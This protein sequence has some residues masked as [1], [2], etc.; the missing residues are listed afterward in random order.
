[1][2]NGSAISEEDSSCGN[3]PEAVVTAA[4][5][6]AASPVATALPATR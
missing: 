4:P 2:T 6:P 1:L 5:T 3:R